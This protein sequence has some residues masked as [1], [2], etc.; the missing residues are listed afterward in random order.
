[1]QG[2]RPL[3]GPVRH[4]QREVRRIVIED[5]QEQGGPRVWAR[6]DVVRE[7]TPDDFASVRLSPPLRCLAD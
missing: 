2:G 3:A 7:M 5:R 4:A 6:F 1:M